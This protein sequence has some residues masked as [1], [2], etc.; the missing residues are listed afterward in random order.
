MAPWGVEVVLSAMWRHLPQAADVLSITE[1]LE[2]AKVV[3]VRRNLR[4]K[5]I[6]L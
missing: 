6:N 4:R 3:I 2:Q 1:Q 5:P